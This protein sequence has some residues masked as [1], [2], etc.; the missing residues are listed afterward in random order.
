MGRQAVARP[1]CGPIG[2]VAQSP[3]DNGIGMPTIV[4]LPAAERAQ[5]D[6]LDVM[7][8][9]VPALAWL[10]QLERGAGGLPRGRKRARADLTG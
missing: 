8:G 5:L 9:E 1:D 2:T 7:R 4:D 10:Q 6:V 3:S